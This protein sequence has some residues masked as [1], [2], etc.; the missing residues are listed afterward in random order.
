[1]RALLLIAALVPLTAQAQDLAT[2]RQL[3]ATAYKDEQA[4]K[5]LLQ[6]VRS[7]KEETGAVQTAYHGAAL[8]VRASQVMPAGRKLKL[9]KEGRNLIEKA[10]AMDPEN[11]EVRFL[12]M[13]V[14]ENAPKILGYNDRIANDK[15]FI[16]EHFPTLKD[17]G[18]RQMIRNHAESSAIYSDEERRL[19]LHG[20]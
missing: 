12:R 3:Y 9:F 6:L 14:Q 18:L 8:M 2:E 10:M 15:H 16:L 4:A 1:M 20:Q 19:L 7:G 17:A 5:E 13:T 11:V